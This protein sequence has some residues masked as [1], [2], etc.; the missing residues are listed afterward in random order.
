VLTMRITPT[1]VLEAAPLWGFASGAAAGCVTG[2]LAAFAG[3]PLGSGRLAAVGPSGWQVGLAAILELGV[4]GALAA[5]AANWFLLRRG[6]GSGD[7]PGTE[8]PGL[9]RPDASAGQPR[10]GAGQVRSR[11][12]QPAVVDE[13]DDQGGHRIYLDPWANETNGPG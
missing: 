2:A 10:A 3:G 7:A 12:G 5:G 8:P 13:T 1:P 11:A 4:T 6:S 9:M